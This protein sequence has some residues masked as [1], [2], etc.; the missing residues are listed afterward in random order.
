MRSLRLLALLACLVGAACS[1]DS[2]DRAAREA[3]WRAEVTAF[4]AHPQDLHDLRD[5]LR[6]VS[7]DDVELSRYQPSTENPTLILPDIDD[8][9]PTGIYIV[10]L[11]ELPSTM[12][13]NYWIAL[14]AS[15]NDNGVV[16]DYE[17]SLRS[18]CL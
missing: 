16:Y 4:F 13:C 6:A 11:E 14:D 10:T 18:A 9:R 17:V 12:V 1:T 8:T 2:I 7:A 15:V 5:W 3:Y